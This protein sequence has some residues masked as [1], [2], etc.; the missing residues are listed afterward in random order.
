[1]SRTVRQI[2]Y[3][4]NERC[5]HIRQMLAE[6]ETVT[7]KEA[8]ALSKEALSL[9]P[10]VHFSLLTDKK[11]P[12]ILLFDLPDT[13]NRTLLAIGPAAVPR[14]QLWKCRGPLLDSEFAG[15]H[16]LSAVKQLNRPF[17]RHPLPVEVAVPAGVAHHADIRGVVPLLDRRRGARSR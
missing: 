13:L 14:K 4:I 15:G 10:N 17:A 6:D 7:N 5:E 9:A 8:A 3:A 11:H 1:A 12:A 16:D 2:I